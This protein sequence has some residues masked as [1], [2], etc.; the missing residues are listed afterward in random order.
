[1]KF[2]LQNMTGHIPAGNYKGVI[3]EEQAT[4]D[5]RYLWLK[6]EVEDVESILHI[7]IPCASTL[8]HTFAAA[9]ADKKGNV[10]TQDFVHTEIEFSVKDREIN[11]TV[12]SRFSKIN[13]V[14]EEENYD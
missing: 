11:G 5:Q 8:F 2:K 10:D 4:S 6:I 7:T 1:M 9:F 12:Y 3:V 13:A 14:M